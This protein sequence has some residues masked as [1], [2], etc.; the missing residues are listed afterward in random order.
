MAHSNSTPSASLQKFAPPRATLRRWAELLLKS[1]ADLDAFCLDHFPAVY[2][3]WSDGMDR[4]RK[5]NLL[6]LLSP[7]EALAQ[8]LLEMNPA[9]LAETESLTE[10]TDHA[11][12]ADFERRP[13]LYCAAA[14]LLL[15][16][17]LLIGGMAYAFMSP[18][19]PRK[20][21]IPAMH[22]RAP[23]QADMLWLRSEPSG[24]L[25][26]DAMTGRIL[27]ETPWQVRSPLAVS[28]SYW[29]LCLRKS[30]FLPQ[31][32]RLPS[33]SPP[34]PLRLIPLQPVARFDGQLSPEQEDCDAK[35]P[36]VD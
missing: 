17:A 34:S 2:Q 32:V 21:T 3:R 36:F 26:I 22:S 14:A 4:L 18:H 10:F 7:R 1:D 12:A 6:L 8:Q 23:Q 31:P 5:L 27:G 35:T 13:R 30:G 24:A 28:P 9:L 20:E 33:P 19:R 29:Q 11:P 25:V 16:A 15:F